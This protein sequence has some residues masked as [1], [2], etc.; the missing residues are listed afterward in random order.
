MKK[1]FYRI[2]QFGMR[3]G[4]Y[5]MPWRKPVLLKGENVINQLPKTLLYK[6]YDRL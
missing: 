6:G 4:S 2:Y 5:L 3:L 1:M